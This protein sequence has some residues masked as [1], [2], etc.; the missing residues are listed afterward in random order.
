MLIQI[1]VEKMIYM[2]SEQS[3]AQLGL[4][5]VAGKR[6][7][8]VTIGKSEA[9]SISLF[10][11]HT[12]LPCPLTH[13]LLKNV[14]D[15]LDGQLRRVVIAD[16]KEGI[17]CTELHIRHGEDTLI[18][19]ARMSDA[20]SLALRSECGIFIDENLLEKLAEADNQKSPEIPTVEELKN[21]VADISKYTT[22]VLENLLAQLL[23]KEDYEMAI[24]IRD[25]LTRRKKDDFMQQ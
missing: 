11:A 22:E 6:R 24:R 10:L 21:G 19:A 12:K 18:L 15:V 5:E 9:D 14:L 25:E 17:F 13:D 3:V 8:S 23:E 4:L 16:I 2:R 1:R 20:V 7:F